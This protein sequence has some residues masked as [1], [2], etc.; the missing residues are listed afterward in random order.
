MDSI[1][2]SE[3]TVRTLEGSLEN[4]LRSEALKKK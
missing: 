2:V 3:V 1:E 4:T